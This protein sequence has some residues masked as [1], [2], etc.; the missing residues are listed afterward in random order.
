MNG[1]PGW[2]V[3]PE[4]HYWNLDGTPTKAMLIKRLRENVKI[5]SL[6][7]WTSDVYG[8]YPCDVYWVDNKT[9]WSCGDEG[10]L[11]ADAQTKTSMMKEAHRG[12]S[13]T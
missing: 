11:L 12:N 4:D 7:P 1:E 8:C 6:I 10:L 13:I 5:V 3:D 2:W 9:C